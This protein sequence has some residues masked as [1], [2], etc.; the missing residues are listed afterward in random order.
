[1]SKKFEPGSA[2]RLLDR[3]EQDETGHL[4]RVVSQLM[5]CSKELSKRGVPLDEIA[6][7]VTMFW[8]V[9]Q[10]PAMEALMNSFKSLNTADENKYN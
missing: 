8:Y 4:R 3:A 6:S 9:G 1:M 5:E 10:I 2:D 7:V